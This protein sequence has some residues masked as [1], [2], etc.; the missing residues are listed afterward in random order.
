M[1]V[2]NKII[3]IFTP[4]YNRAYKIGKLYNSL[5]NQTNKNFIWHIVDDGSTDNTAELVKGW[6]NE[7]QIE[8]KYSFQENGG[9]QRAHNKGVSLCDTELFLCV[10]SDDYLTNNAIEELIHKWNRIV[11]KT[12]ISGIVAMC[13]YTESDPVKNWLPENVKYSTLKDLYSKYKFRGDTL[14]L[15]RSDI[16]RQYPFIVAE[17]EKFIGENYVYLQ[18]D[19]KYQLCLLHKILYICEYLPDGYSLNVRKVIKKNPKGYMT[20]N[21]LEVLYSKK[22]RLKYINS[23]KYMVGCILSK[24]KHP[25]KNSSSKFLAVLAYFP[26]LIYL[27]LKFREK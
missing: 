16:L 9:K 6:I 11:D 10:D 5:L 24:E 20:L 8:I 4:T 17:D 27:N 23:I 22:L 18:I 15:Y 2:S 26:A 1:M 7:D 12:N 19:Q 3:T 21:Q 13:G 14:L 25:I